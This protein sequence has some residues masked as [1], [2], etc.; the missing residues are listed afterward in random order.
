M[1]LEQD[2]YLRRLAK[3]RAKKAAKKV[4]FADRLMELYP[5][6]PGDPKSI[7]EQ[8]SKRRR[9]GT[10]K[11]INMDSAIHLAVAA[12]ARHE[13]TSYDQLLASGMKRPV[14]RGA[15]SY[16]LSR[17]LMEWAKPRPHFW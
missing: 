16:P 3:I 5:R 14:A 10:S 2:P 7:A 4:N 1:D 17:I 6:F 13:H 15:I 8:S 11:S 12:Y 9:V